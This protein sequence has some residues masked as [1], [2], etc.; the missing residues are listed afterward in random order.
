MANTKK[1]R[2]LETTSCV[3]RNQERNDDI[4]RDYIGFLKAGNAIGDIY[5][6]LSHMYERSYRTI[7]NIITTERKAAGRTIEDDR[8]LAREAKERRK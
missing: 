1:Y 5:V 8:R 6:E 4:Y 7:Q 2:K 3:W